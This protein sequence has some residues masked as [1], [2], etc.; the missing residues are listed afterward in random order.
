MIVIPS[1]NA[2]TFEEVKEKIKLVEP[3]VPPAGGWVHLDISDG[4]FSKTVTWHEPSDL[5]SLETSLN[6]EAHL[7]INNIEEK[8]DNWLVTQVKR[9]F[10]HLGAC[11]D[12]DFVIEK[13]KNAGKEPG[14]AISP[15]ESW[16]KAVH[17]KGKVNNF[18]ILGVA[19]GP[20]G[21][22]TEEET[23]TRIR[24]L[25]NICGSCIIEADGGMN[26]NVAKRAKEAGADIIV[27]A[28]AIFNGNIKKNIE[29]LKCI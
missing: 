13:I 2:E 12:P 3:Y 5:L 10:F 23:F 7:M 17:F 18:Q 19:P 9:I 8:I 11:N 27:A 22:K 6:M 16:T 28:T 4:T 20:A 24:E 26:I 15:D 29:E 1:I 14:I 25:K 21:Q